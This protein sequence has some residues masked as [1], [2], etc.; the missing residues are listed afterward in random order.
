MKH[1][2]GSSSRQQLSWLL[3]MVALIL[4]AAAGEGFRDFDRRKQAQ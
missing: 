1:S 4:L 3:L 2:A